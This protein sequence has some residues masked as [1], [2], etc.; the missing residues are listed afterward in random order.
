VVPEA[1]LF[2]LTVDTLVEAAMDLDA[3]A[4]EPFSPMAARENEMRMGK[5]WYG[6]LRP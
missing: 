3:D 6:A 2:V 4:G 5:R 1:K